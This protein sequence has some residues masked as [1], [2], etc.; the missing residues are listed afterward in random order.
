[1]QLSIWERV[2]TVLAQL[3]TASH[4]KVSN[5][6]SPLR[7]LNTHLVKPVFRSVLVSNFS[8]R[9]RSPTTTMSSGG[10]GGG[11]VWD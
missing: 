9:I 11:T 8:R 5:A 2:V 6:V 1:M 7:R 3:R 10:G 4:I